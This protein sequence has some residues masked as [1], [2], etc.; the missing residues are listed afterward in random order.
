MYVFLVCLSTN[1]FFLHSIIFKIDLIVTFPFRGRLWKVTDDPLTPL[2]IPSWDNIHTHIQYVQ[3]NL[4]NTR[5]KHWY[6]NR[7]YVL[8]KTKSAHKVCTNRLLHYHWHEIIIHVYKR[9]PL[10]MKHTAACFNDIPEAF[11]W[12]SPPLCEDFM[13]KFADVHACWPHMTVVC[14][15]HPCVPMCCRIMLIRQR[16]ELWRVSPAQSTLC[17]VHT[18]GRRLCLYETV[19]L[20]WP[21]SSVQK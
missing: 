10:W 19:C 13:R 14:F 11:S 2:P 15:A 18:G 8:K 7:L 6:L 20:R 17:L 3:I 1:L 12:C 16:Y 4:A 21:W 9:L 5:Q